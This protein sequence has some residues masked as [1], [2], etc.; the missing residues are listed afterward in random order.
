M[1]M[2]TYFKIDHSGFTLIELLVTLAIFA[3]ALT[4]AANI[5][6]YTQRAQRRTEN[7]QATQT[8]ARFALE[9]MSQEIRHSNIDYAFYGG[10]I[11]VGPQGTLALSGSDGTRLQFHRIVSA[12]RG[13]VQVSLDAGATW[14]DL[15][16][17]DVSVSSLAFYLSPPTDP[18]APNPSS[19]QPPLV[20]IVMRTTGTRP[21]ATPTFVQTTVSARQYLR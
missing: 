4:A 13:L 18:F 7:I 3:G 10:A 11:G 21:E 1:N 20:T 5:F 15:T 8:D 9:V 6:L 14:I 17:T 2:S 16:P 12:G 19:N